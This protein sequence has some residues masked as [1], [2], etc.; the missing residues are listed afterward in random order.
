VRAMPL[1]ASRVSGLTRAPVYAQK[2]TY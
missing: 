2:R 1:E